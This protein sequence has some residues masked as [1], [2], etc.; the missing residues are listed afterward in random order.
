MQYRLSGEAF[1][2]DVDTLNE[3]LKLRGAQRLRTA[4][5]PDEAFGMI[6]CFDGIIADMQQVSSQK[7]DFKL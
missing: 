3:K 4:M 7:H 2:L 5:R 1:H 6:F